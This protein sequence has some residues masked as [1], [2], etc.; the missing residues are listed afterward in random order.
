MIALTSQT[1]IVLLIATVLPSTLSF[2]YPI[3][4]IANYQRPSRA[5]SLP[6]SYASSSSSSS[7]YDRSQPSYYNGYQTTYDKQ[8]TNNYYGNDRPEREYYYGKPTYHGEYKPTRYYYAREPNYNYYDDH[9][10]ADTNPLDDLH[11]EMLQEDQ[12]D[13]QRNWPADK[14]Q[15]FQNTGEP[16][17]LTN[18]FLK[19]LML[20]NNGINPIE[21]Q[22]QPQPQP[23]AD[24]LNNAYTDDEDNAYY[25]DVQNQSPY[26]YYDSLMDP[27]TNHLASASAVAAP[28]TQNQGDYFGHSNTD[29]DDFNY[30]TNKGQLPYGDYETEQ[31]ED[32]EEQDL[33]S[34]RKQHKNTWDSS[35]NENFDPFGSNAKPNSLKSHDTFAPNSGYESGI[36]Y[37]EEDDGAWINWD[38]KRSLAKK[39]QDG[40]RPL[41]ALEYRLTSLQ[42][43]L[44]ND[45]T[46]KIS[47]TSPPSTTTIR[48]FDYLEE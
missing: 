43:K 15:W 25:S 20:Y 39:Q 27:R 3:Y 34:L 32:K 9:T 29:H 31:K 30:A 16:K 18:N 8:P 40:L 1:L 10:E 37:D 46:S 11:E 35:D 26:D 7:Q 23:Q 38:R 47:T 4:N 48:Y 33:K 6:T 21:Q 19:N 17:S 28:L 13:R 14:A 2:T 41:K 22:Q 45:K 44:K 12:R 24:S 42:D 36:D 5:S